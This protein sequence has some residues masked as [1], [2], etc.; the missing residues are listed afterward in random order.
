MNLR[1]LGLLLILLVLGACGGET[2]THRVSP[3]GIIAATPQAASPAFVEI[4]RP[5]RA[6]ASGARVAVYETTQR[7]AGWNDRGRFAL[8]SESPRRILEADEAGRIELGRLGVGRHLLVARSE[9]FAGVAVFEV[10]VAGSE[11]A[12]RHL[13]AVARGHPPRMLLWSARRV[14]VSVRDDRDRAVGHVPVTLFPG[15]RRIA[16]SC[17]PGSR[18]SDIAMYGAR[19]FTDGQGRVVFL[20]TRADRSGLF[21]AA[22]LKAEIHGA[23]LPHREV[24]VPSRGAEVAIQLELP[25]L[26]DVSVA[27]RHADSGDGLAVVSWCRDAAGEPGVRDVVWTHDGAIV[28][29]ITDLDFLTL[30]NDA[31]SRIPMIPGSWIRFRVDRPGHQPGFQTVRIPF[32]VDRHLV[33]L[34]AG[35]PSPR[36]D[37]RFLNARGEPLDLSRFRLVRQGRGDFEIDPR[38]GG[39]P[40]AASFCVPPWQEHEIVFRHAS[41]PGFGPVN[42]SS[43]L[44]RLRVPKL[45][46]DRD[47]HLGDVIVREPPILVAGQVVDARGF[48]V[49]GSV[50]QVL[51]APPGPSVLNGRRMQVAAVTTDERGRFLVAG[52]PHDYWRYV[53]RAAGAMAS[54]DIAFTSGQSDL[55]IPVREAGALAGRLVLADERLFPEVVLELESSGPGLPRIL[56]LEEGGAFEANDLRPGNYSLVV[57]LGSGRRRIVLQRLTDLPVSSGQ[58]AR[59]SLLE[60][61]RLGDGLRAAEVRVVDS[62]DAPCAGAIVKWA[63]A[64]GVEAYEVMRYTGL[65]GTA[66]A[67]IPREVA[68]KV[69]VSWWDESTGARHWRHVKVPDARFPLTVRL[70]P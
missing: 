1:S 51:A 56:R 15:H 48:G 23:A 34:E 19:G 4:F 9:G 10:P 64:E 67:F 59:P 45:L 36:V 43:E 12:R 6:P 26:C 2:E 52:P 49:G 38:P 27:I 5:G 54:E 58:T 39:S 57:S 41:V 21:D 30:R 40:A 18:T 8:P 25:R 70:K 32:T 31:A 3:E 46:L 29:S 47:H 68:A 11:V 28:S 65:R 44:H 17:L 22:S 69:E 42:W 55:I 14:T 62:G 13:A 53:A 37:G 63:G 61:L 35:E 66:L 33:T 7:A 50:V 60:A 16:T 20:L 24:I